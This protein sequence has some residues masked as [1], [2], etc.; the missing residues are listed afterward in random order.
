MNTMMQLEQ[1]GYIFQLAIDYNGPDN[2]PADAGPLL[3]ELA[4]NRDEAIRLLTERKASE[5]WTA[6]PPS[7]GDAYKIIFDGN[8]EGQRKRWALAAQTGFIHLTDKVEVSTRSGECIIRFRYATP[9]EWLEQDITVEVKRQYNA[10]LERIHRGESW[11]KA[12]IDDP[13]YEEHFARFIALFD[14]LRE[15]YNSINETLMDPF[16]GYQATIL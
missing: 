1:M 6:V 5:A 4:L 2:P 11:L 10:V 12:S 13:R 16:A 7:E 15:L 14:D 9:L 8:D 3:D